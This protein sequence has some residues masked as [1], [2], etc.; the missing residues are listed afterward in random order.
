MRTHLIDR[1]SKIFFHANLLCSYDLSTAQ[2]DGIPLKQG[3]LDLKCHDGK[4][5]GDHGECVRQQKVVMT[6]EQKAAI[7]KEEALKKALVL[8]LPF[9]K[10]TTDMSSKVIQRAQLRPS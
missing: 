8:Y 4:G 2:V 3:S 6:D 9:T 1:V 7:K 10:D 5:C